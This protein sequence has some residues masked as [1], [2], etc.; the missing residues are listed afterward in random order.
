MRI[1]LIRQQSDIQRTG[2]GV[3]GREVAI[4]QRQQLGIVS[5][6]PSGQTYRGEIADRVGQRVNLG[7]QPAACW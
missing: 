4:Q 2:I 7:T 6:L 3:A 5:G 1:R